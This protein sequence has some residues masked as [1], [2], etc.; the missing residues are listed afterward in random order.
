MTLFEY[1]HLG[2]LRLSSNFKELQSKEATQI[3]VHLEFENFAIKVF[4]PFI[5]LAKTK[6]KNSERK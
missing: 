2:I 1:I 6:K 4:W 3:G 5:I